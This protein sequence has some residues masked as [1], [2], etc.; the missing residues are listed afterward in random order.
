[1][2]KMDVHFS[3]ATD[4]WYTPPEIFEELDK[5]FGFVLDPCAN[6]TN[7]KCESWYGPD[8]PDLSRRD[9]LS[10]DWATEVMLIGGGGVFIN[11]PYGRKIKNWVR[12]S[13]EC[14]LSGINCVLLL[15]S[16]TD[17]SW[18]HD[19]CINEEVRFLRGRI[20]FGG[21]TNSAPFPSC[22]VVMRGKND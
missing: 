10:C 6:S 2:N 14:S 20:K 4:L 12:K 3:S 16:R 11:P 21:S 18:F 1:M 17:T 7:H 5:E 19:Y 8:H 9:G 15:P 13:Y 22:I